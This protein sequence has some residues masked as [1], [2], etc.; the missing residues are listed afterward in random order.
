MKRH[1]PI[2]LLLA[3]CVFAPSL[4][5]QSSSVT[6]VNA[7][8]GE[9]RY[10]NSEDETG[11]YLIQLTDAQGGF[12]VDGTMTKG[13]GTLLNV[14]LTGPKAADEYHPAL[15]T[16]TYAFS[17]DNSSFTFGDNNESYVLECVEKDGSETSSK[18]ALAGGTIVV[19]PGEN[20]FYNVHATVT[21]A[22]DSPKEFI[23]SYNGPL[24]KTNMCVWLPGTVY[25]VNAPNLISGIYDKDTG[26]YMLTL[27]GVGFNPDGLIDSGGDGMVIMLVRDN[28]TDYIKDLPGTYTYTSAYNIGSWEDGCYVG[29]CFLELSPGYD[30]PYGTMV[31]NYDD[32]G[33]TRYCGIAVGGT[34]N[35]ENVGTPADGNIKIEYDLISGNGCRIVGKW[36]GNIIGKIQNLGEVG[37]SEIE[38]EEAAV[39]GLQ[40]RIEAP[41]GARVYTL[42][43][44]VSEKENLTPG[45]Y[46]V[47]T[48]GKAVKVAVK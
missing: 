13:P 9:L 14:V 38:S 32:S 41:E 48:D 46:I 24:M 22:G 10:S 21:T 8:L 3:S 35:I 45:I 6:T 12:Q 23:F 18:N 39:R 26:D 31:C 11:A 42:S 43:G 29:G 7:L 37:I 4:S 34:I 27:S 44:T 30:V 33:L 16:G 25:E 5:A 47:I 40:G 19:E 2:V 36:E 15:P 17:T 1:L 28:S 20:G